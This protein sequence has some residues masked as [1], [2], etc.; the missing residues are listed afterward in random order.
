MR[1]DYTI[2]RPS[3]TAEQDH[4]L[5]EEWR[6]ILEKQRVLESERGDVTG[7]AVAKDDTAIEWQKLNNRKYEIRNKLFGTIFN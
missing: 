4:E 3:F 2:N 1:A 6:D 7:I 5:I